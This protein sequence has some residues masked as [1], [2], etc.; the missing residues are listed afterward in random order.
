MVPTHLQ[1]KLL[2]LAQEKKLDLCADDL[3]KGRPGA[4]VSA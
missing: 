2:D 1:K 4:E 3:I